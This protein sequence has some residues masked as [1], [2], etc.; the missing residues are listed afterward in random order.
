MMSSNGNFDDFF[1]LRL[2]KR[3]SKQSRRRWFETSPCSL[4]RHC[5]V[6][7]HAHVLSL[8]CSTFNIAPYWLALELRCQP[9]ESQLIVANNIT[10][11]TSKRWQCE[12]QIGYC[13]MTVWWTILDLICKNSNVYLLTLI[14]IEILNGEPGYRLLALWFM[15]CLAPTFI[16]KSTRP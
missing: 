2:N 16:L 13:P 10:N 8:W 9:I 1:D 6:M 14:S 7:L 3:F 11:S 4:W 15:T 12:V 5:N